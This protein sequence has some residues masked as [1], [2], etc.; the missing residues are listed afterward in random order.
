MLRIEARIHRIKLN[1]N[2]TKKRKIP[3]ISV[4]SCQKFLYHS[5]LSDCTTFIFALNDC[6]YTSLCYQ[7]VIFG[8]KFNQRRGIRNKNNC[9][10]LLLEFELDICWNCSIS[11]EK[12]QSS[13][14]CQFTWNSLLRWQSWNVTARKYRFQSLFQNKNSFRARARA[15][16]ALHAPILT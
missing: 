16:F 6:T 12:W 7:R 4:S 2:W 13:T 15:E 3:C 10:L 1:C 11:K 14:A 8:P 5:F 9:N